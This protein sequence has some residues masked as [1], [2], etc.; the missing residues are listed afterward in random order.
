MPTY[1]Y[2]CE[3]CGCVFEKFQSIMANPVEKCTKCAGKVRRLISGGSGILF[4]GSGFYTTDYRGNDY[5]KKAD[6]ETSETK[7]DGT[8]T[9]GCDNE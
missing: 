7:T 2:A 9:E 3:S 1:E 8:V 6:S 4:K 5:K